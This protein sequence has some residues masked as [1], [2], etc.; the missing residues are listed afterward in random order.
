MRIV[1]DTNVIVSALLW[2]GIPHQ[3]LLAAEHRLVELYSSPALLEE[4]EGVL[5][6]P[7][8]AR[9]LQALGTTPEELLSGYAQLATLVLPRG[10]S[11]VVLDD[12]ADDAVLACVVAARATY[13]VT[14]DSDLL[15][16]DSYEGIRIVS[17]GAFVRKVIR[18]PR[19]K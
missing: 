7:K 15:R 4:L 16:L 11:R 8:F 12:L 19:D 17:P 13:L 6:R 10:T 14:G 1:A 3:I 5:S 9:R 2:V 18:L